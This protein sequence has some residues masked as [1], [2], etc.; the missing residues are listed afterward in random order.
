MRKKHSM[1]VLLTRKK[2][3]LKDSTPIR[4]KGKNQKLNEINKLSPNLQIQETIQLGILRINKVI[5][6]YNYNKELL[7]IFNAENYVEINMHIVTDTYVKQTNC[8]VLL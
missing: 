7:N 1:L 8:I 6:K 3:Q 5:V 4:S 2:M